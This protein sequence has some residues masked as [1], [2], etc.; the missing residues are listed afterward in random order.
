MSLSFTR[1]VTTRGV[2]SSY[3]IRD[4]DAYFFIYV[5]FDN[6]SN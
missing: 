4:A 2:L 5:K 1:L 3:G 6:L